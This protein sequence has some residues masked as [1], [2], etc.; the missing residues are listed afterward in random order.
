VVKNGFAATA[1]CAADAHNANIAHSDM[2][3]RQT[4]LRRIAPG[5][6]RVG[7]GLTRVSPCAMP[8]M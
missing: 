5:P 7:G 8:H 4:S 2:H 3:Q 1:C 6:K